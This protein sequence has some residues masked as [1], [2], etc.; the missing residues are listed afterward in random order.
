LKIPIIHFYGGETTEGANDEAYRHAITKLSHLHFTSTEF[1]RK[2]V[3]QLGEHPSSVYNIG[4]IGVEN[5]KNSRKLSIQELSNLL[6]INLVK[7]FALVTYHPET[8]G[9][10]DP[11]D[12]IKTIFTVCSSF[13]DINFIFTKSNIDTGG[14][15]INSFLEKNIPYS[16]NCFLFDSLGVENY[17]SLLSYAIFV[18]GNSSS[19]LIEV[20]SFKIPTINVGDRQKGRL[21]A[22]TIINSKLDEKCIKDSI[23]SVLNSPKHIFRNIVNPYGDGNTTIKFLKVFKKEVKKSNVNLKKTFYTCEV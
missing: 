20:P 19:G 9:D 4:A 15:E 2:R 14:Y 1:Y 10:I 6:G 11:I 23:L 13:K 8:L 7:P 17:L 18:L 16:G 12:Q 3:I 21:Q 5:I 22:K